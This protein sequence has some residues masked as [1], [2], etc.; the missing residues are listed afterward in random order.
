MW[1][2]RSDRRSTASAAASVRSTADGCRRGWRP[3][4][5]EVRRRANDPRTYPATYDE[6]RDRRRGDRARG[7]RPPAPLRGDRRGGPPRPRLRLAAG[8]PSPGMP[9]SETSLA[10][11]RVWAPL[12][13]LLVTDGEP[14]STP[15]GDRLLKRIGRGWPPRRPRRPGGRAAH[16]A[17]AQADLP[18]AGGRTTTTSLRRSRCCCC[19][20]LARR[21]GTSSD[22]PDGGRRPRP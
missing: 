3:T 17:A 5:A 16:G 6:L 7:S 18:A 19:A 20:V 10:V 12:H 4:T 21:P 8:T 15:E 13:L 2:T 9:I 14:P 1:A 22:R 11:L